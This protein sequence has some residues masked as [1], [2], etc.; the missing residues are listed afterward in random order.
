MFDRAYEHLLEKQEVEARAAYGIYK[1]NRA[2]WHNRLFKILDIAS[3]VVLTI[4][5]YKLPTGQ[6][7]WG[8]YIAG[9]VLFITVMAEKRLWG[10]TVMGCILLL[11]AIKNLLGL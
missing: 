9:S 8:L 10:N 3:S 4:A 5:V 6:G 7:W 11:L 2:K 1:A